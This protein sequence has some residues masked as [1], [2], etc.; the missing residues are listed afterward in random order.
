ML[1]NVALSYAS[2]H[3]ERALV[4]TRFDQERRALTGSEPLLEAFRVDPEG[5]IVW[6]WERERDLPDPEDTVRAASA[7]LLRAF[8]RLDRALPGTF[9]PDRLRRITEAVADDLAGL[10]F[11]R[12]LG[13]LAEPNLLSQDEDHAR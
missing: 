2:D 5:V 9:P 12:E 6:E 11:Y 1:L 7:W 13:F 10:G 3:L 4:A 8:L